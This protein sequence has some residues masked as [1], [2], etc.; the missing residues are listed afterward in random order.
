M[1]SISLTSLPQAHRGS[2]AIT[3]HSDDVL[4]CNFIGKN[5]ILLYR[6]FSSKSREEVEDA[7]G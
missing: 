4:R 2:L 6:C 7:K 5:V 3:M 1:N